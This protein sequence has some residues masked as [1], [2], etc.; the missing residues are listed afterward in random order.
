M[1]KRDELLVDAFIDDRCRAAIMATIGRDD[2]TGIVHH[3][4]RRYDSIGLLRFC[5]RMSQYA[6]SGMGVPREAML[7]GKVGRVSLVWEDEMTGEASNPDAEP[8]L[9]PQVWA[10]RFITATLAQDEANV[11]ALFMIAIENARV[12][13]ERLSA[14]IGL[15]AN[16]CAQAAWGEPE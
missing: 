7:A 14:L 8:E 11:E 6:A 4:M 9:A 13:S 10:M 2:P 3:V 16:S 1:D 15:A 5:V 12:L